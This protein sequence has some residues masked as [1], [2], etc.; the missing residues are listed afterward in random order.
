MRPSKG[1]LKVNYT[2]SLIQLLH[3]DRPENRWKMELYLTASIHSDEIRPPSDVQTKLEKCMLPQRQLSSTR[4]LLQD[5]RA[6]ALAV[7]STSFL[8]RVLRQLKT[9]GS[10]RMGVAAFSWTVLRSRDGGLPSAPCQ[11]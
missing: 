6:I 10:F 1:W 4:A 5:E 3:P 2:Q 7:R 11:R 9:Q 8:V